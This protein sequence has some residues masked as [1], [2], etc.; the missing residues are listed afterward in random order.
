MS[1]SHAT[2]HCLGSNASGPARV[3]PDK[4]ILFPTIRVTTDTSLRI[5]IPQS[6]LSPWEGEGEHEVE[7]SVVRRE[8]E[9]EAGSGE[10]RT[11][12]GIHCLFWACSPLGATPFH[13][14]LRLRKGKTAEVV[15]VL[16]G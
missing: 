14:F 6:I 11:K 13:R 15:S 12:L 10:S 2:L 3:L 1:P 16:V 5:F 8:G 4:S 7:C 9:M